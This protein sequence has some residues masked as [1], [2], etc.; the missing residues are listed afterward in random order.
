MN[1]IDI[2]LILAIVKSAFSGFKRGFFR[3]I[4]DIIAIIFSIIIAWKYMDIIANFFYQSLPFFNINIS[5]KIV[6]E[7]INI[8]TILKYCE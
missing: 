8:F 1:I 7:S 2:L 5:V 6:H 4:L 3:E